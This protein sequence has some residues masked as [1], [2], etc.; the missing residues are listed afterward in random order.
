MSV[1]FDRAF[2]VYSIVCSNIERVIELLPSG[3]HLMSVHRQTQPGDPTALWATR[4]EQTFEK[5][6]SAGYIRLYER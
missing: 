2:E 3:T 6:A 4:V 1:A 5:L